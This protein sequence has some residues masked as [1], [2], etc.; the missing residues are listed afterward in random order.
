M[1]S[2]KNTLALWSGLSG[3]VKSTHHVH[4]DDQT[5]W[6]HGTFPTMGEIYAFR[7]WHDPGARILATI[8]EDK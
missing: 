3:P 6:F 2:K 8:P 1:D 4:L 5:M 7:A